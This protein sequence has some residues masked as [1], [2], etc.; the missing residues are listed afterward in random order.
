M[1]N[2]VVCSLAS[3]PAGH[4]NVEK[5]VCAEC[6]A[7]IWVSSSS[8]KVSQEAPNQWSFI[9]EKCA[10]Q[11]MQEGSENLSVMFP[12]ADQIKEISETLGIS[13]EIAKERLEAIIIAINFKNKFKQN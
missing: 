12:T 1:N 3:K 5:G 6:N 9:C 7:E 13:E 11:E 10:L 4:P 8:K 2:A